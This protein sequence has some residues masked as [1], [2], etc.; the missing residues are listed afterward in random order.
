MKYF[1]D[2]I[3]LS[4]GKMRRMYLV[5]LK[6][7]HT[8]LQL[9]A[10][11]GECKRCGACC[12]LNFACPAMDSNNGLCVCWLYEERSKVCRSFPIDQ[13]DLKD[14][15]RVLPGTKCGYRFEPTE[16]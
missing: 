2:H 12:K 8:K 13:R 6:P 15:D 5:Y 14:R 10:R 1:I 3:V 16:H 7:K 11:Q 4:W 9:N